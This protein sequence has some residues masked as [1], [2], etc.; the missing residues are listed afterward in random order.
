MPSPYVLTL[1]TSSIT[2]AIVPMYLNST[3][4][5][6]PHKIALLLFSAACVH[7]DLPIN[8]PFYMPFLV[9]LEK[10]DP[11]YLVHDQKQK[12]IAL[13]SSLLPLLYLSKP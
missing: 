1:L 4:T 12:S 13:G 11:D 5:L 8:L 3:Y 10:N 6:S 9:F 2:Y 7:S